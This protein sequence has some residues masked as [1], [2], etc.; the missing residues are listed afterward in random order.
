MKAKDYF[1]GMDFANGLE[2]EVISHYEGDV[3][4]IDSIR[5]VKNES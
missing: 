4:V 3:I 5:Q 2:T 1:I